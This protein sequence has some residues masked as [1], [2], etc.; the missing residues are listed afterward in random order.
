MKV[1]FGEASASMVPL[2]DGLVVE[3]AFMG[4]L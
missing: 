3:L 4:I 2:L 1:A